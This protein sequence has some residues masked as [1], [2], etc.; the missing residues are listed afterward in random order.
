MFRPSA[1][2]P[3][4]QPR[5]LARDREQDV[6]RARLLPLSLVTRPDAHVDL[7]DDCQLPILLLL[8]VRGP[9]FW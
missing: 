7:P 3:P 8:L 1:S 2:D 5:V 6:L 4:V 9:H